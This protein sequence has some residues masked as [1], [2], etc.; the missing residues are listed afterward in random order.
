MEKSM[1]FKLSRVDFVAISIHH[2]LG[3]KNNSELRE[4]SHCPE[5]CLE[6]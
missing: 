1:Y 4:K 6:L 5:I 3:P 2:G